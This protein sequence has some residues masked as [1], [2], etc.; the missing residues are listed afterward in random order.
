M[1]PFNLVVVL[2]TDGRLRVLPGPCLWNGM[3]KQMALNHLLEQAR[4]HQIPLPRGM[5]VWSKLLEWVRLV[6]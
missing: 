6:R 1:D 2:V 3:K 5:G 4:S